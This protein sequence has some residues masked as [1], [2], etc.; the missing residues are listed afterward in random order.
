MRER[1]VAAAAGLGSYGGGLCRSIELMVVGVVGPREDLDLLS[2]LW[3][4]AEGCGAG[5]PPGGGGGGGC[6]GDCLA[7][8]VADVLPLVVL[9]LEPGLCGSWWCVFASRMLGGGEPLLV[10]PEGA[11]A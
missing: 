6:A 10:P 11:P 8:L 5:P 3:G 4:V 1:E 7:E 9:L 2:M